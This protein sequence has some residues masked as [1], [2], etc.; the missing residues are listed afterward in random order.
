LAR[1]QKKRQI[2]LA[3]CLDLF[4]HFIPISRVLSWMVIYLDLPLLTNSSDLPERK[5][6]KTSTPHS[7]GTPLLHGLA[8]RRD[9]RVSLLKKT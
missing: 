8:S 9:Y 2:A 4:S 1:P 5:M 6:A 7:I 3:I